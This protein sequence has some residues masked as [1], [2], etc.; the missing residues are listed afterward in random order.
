ML[1]LALFAVL[2]LLATLVPA[3]VLAQSAAEVDVAAQAFETGRYEDALEQYSRLLETRAHGAV[4]DGALELGYARTLTAVGRYPEA[5]DVLRRF[6]EAGGSAPGVDLALGRALAATGAQA[7]AEERFREILSTGGAGSLQAELELAT[8]LRLRGEIE[9]ARAHFYRLIDTYN[10]GTAVSARDLLAV[11]EACRR[12]GDQNP[13]LFKD[14]LKAFDEAIALDPGLIEARV[15][16]ARLFL[17]KYNSTLARGELRQA[18]EANPQHAGAHLAMARILHFEGSPVAM[19]EARR[20]LEINEG[21]GAARVFVAE[22]LLELEQ[23][24]DAEVEAQRAL[25]VNPGDLEALSAL[26]AAAYLRGDSEDFETIETRV[27][28]KNPRYADFYNLLADACVRNRFY[29]QAV[30]FAKRAVELDPQS[31]RGYGLLG[32][33]QLRVGEIER[34]RRNLETA[35]AGDPYNVWIKNTLDLVDSWDEFEIRSSD[36]FSFLGHRREAEL[37]A[38]YALALAEEAYEALAARYRVEPPT[39]IRLE[40]YEVDADFSVR[41]IGL[42]GMGA[43]GVC[44][45]EVIAQDSPR[46]RPRGTFNWGSTLWHEIAH[47]FT[48]AASGH[49]VPRWLTEGLSVLEERRARQGWG[50]DVNPKFLAAW[51]DDRLLPIA[52]I[53]N[54]FVRPDSPEQIGLSYM[55]AS[56]ACELIERDHGFDTLLA[57][58]HGYRDGLSTEELFRELLGVEMA[59]FDESFET[60]LSERFGT[61]LAAMGEPEDEA[62]A[63]RSIPPALEELAARA[64]ERPEHFGSQLGYG[65]ALVAEGRADEAIPF[66]RKAKSLFP[67]YVREGS[68]Y[69]LLEQIHRQRGELEEEAAELAGIVAINENDY[70]SRLELARIRHELGDGEAAIEALEGAVFVFPYEVSLHDRLAKLHQE[71]GNTTGVVRARQSIVALKP[72]DGAQALFELATAHQLDGNRSAAVR[73]VL[74]ALEV[75]PNYAPAQRL[76]LKMHRM[77]EDEPPTQDPSAKLEVDTE[78]EQT[79][80]EADTSSVGGER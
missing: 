74:G 70:D 12:L 65:A 7:E 10:R 76:L 40:F 52:D 19:V 69:H 56:Y 1:A 28:E 24:G 44:F 47:S 71:H 63:A 54:G 26:A 42:A 34:G 5:V 18:L 22:L 21:F 33:N 46:A 3:V 60:Y 66:L 16:L 67:Y 75:A 59:A 57:M 77:R 27:L 41:T 2:A 9:E 37:L 68:P 38:P 11:G 45:G 13:Q 49:K 17:E 80:P 78:P 8:S 36:R 53:N 61:A 64:E 35:F 43:L 31:W 55:Q 23:Y 73:A 39:P 48:L 51:R 15:A 4:S 58:L 14:A 20:A 25:E 62:E 72:V 32:L 6:R 50:D 30:D 79:E 29:K